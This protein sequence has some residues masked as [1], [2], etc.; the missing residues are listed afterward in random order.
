M[1]GESTQRRRRIAAEIQRVGWE[2][3]VLNVERGKM[4]EIRRANSSVEY[5]GKLTSWCISTCG[6]GRSRTLSATSLNGAIHGAKAGYSSRAYNPPA[7][8]GFSFS[9]FQIHQPQPLT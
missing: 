2:F 9:P 6:G 7:I 1:L 4:A 5:R 8:S 3:E